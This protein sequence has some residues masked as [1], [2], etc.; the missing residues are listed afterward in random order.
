MSWIFDHPRQHQ[1]TPKESGIYFKVLKT[2]KV[3]VGDTLILVK[4]NENSA[5]IAEVYETKK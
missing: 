4:K 3:N 5:T 2:G 1:A